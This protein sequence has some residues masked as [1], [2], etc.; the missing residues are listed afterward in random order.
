MELYGSDAFRKMDDTLQNY[1]GS[2]ILRKKTFKFKTVD[3]E[4]SNCCFAIF[5]SLRFRLSQLT[6]RLENAP[7]KSKLRFSY[8][9]TS[10]AG[11]GEAPQKTSDL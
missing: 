11:C 9:L 5:Q 10:G 1:V 8:I 4:I 6:H 3:F 7:K 2:K